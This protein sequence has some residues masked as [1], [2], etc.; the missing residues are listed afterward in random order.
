[1]RGGGSALTLFTFAAVLGC[2]RPVERV[3]PAR[4]SP[5]SSAAPNGATRLP[6]AAPSERTPTPVAP[7]VAAPSESSLGVV[8]LG[9]YSDLDARVQ[10]PP[11]ASGVPLTGVIDS[12]HSTLVVYANGWPHKV[13]PL[14]GPA[15]LLVGSER[16]ALRAGDRSEL[17][18]RLAPGSLRH[19]GPLEQAPPGDR[20]DDGIPDPLDLLLGAKKTVLDGAS[21]DDAYFSLKYPGGDPPRDRGAC[22]DVIVRAARNAG[23]DLQQAVIEDE[24][25]AGASYG[26]TRPDSNIDHRRVRNAIVFFQRHWDARS[27]LLDD[28]AD[29]LRP[30]DVVFLDT[31]PSRPGPDHVGVLAQ[32]TGESGRPLVI[33]LWTFG[34]TTQ[35][36]DLLAFVPVTHR[37]RFPSRSR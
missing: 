15:E 19:L 16:L 24:R 7:A 4:S 37:F 17:S 30:G 11:P 20:D 10:L 23:V 21:Y 9:V 35:A 26:V 25:R 33:N 6:P 12:R 22:V 14:G 2:A 13:Y 18:G 31:F 34:Y 29:P 32:E 27:A 36:M 3:E 1:M 28:A 5:G 8:D